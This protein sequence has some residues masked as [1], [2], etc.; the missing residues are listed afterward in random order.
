MAVEQNVVT[1]GGSAGFS[2]AHTP[3]DVTVSRSSSR[4]FDIGIT[5]STAIT[6]SDSPYLAG[7]PSDVIV[8]GGAN[9]RFISSIEIYAE[10]KGTQS[11]PNLCVYGRSLLQFLPE[12]VSTW[13]MSVYEIEKTIERIGAAL[14]DTST[15]M[16]NVDASLPEPKD[17]LAKQIENWQTVLANYRNATGEGQTES[18]AKALQQELTE[19]Q[20]K[21]REFLAE[22]VKKGNT[23]FREFLSDGLNEMEKGKLLH[24]SREQQ[25]SGVPGFDMWEG[26]AAEKESE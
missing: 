26:K 21:F 11:A 22:S 14:A 24:D 12:Q 15:K 6:T 2:Y 8:G 23:K 9:L 10:D 5:F 19:Y 4:H 18:V 17:N 7:Q 13:V 1:F 3:T 16:E 20:D 25:S